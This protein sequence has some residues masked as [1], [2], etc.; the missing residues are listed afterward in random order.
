MFNFLF[1][2]ILL[3]DQIKKA[4]YDECGDYQVYQLQQ[5]RIYH[6]EFIIP[7]SRKNKSK[8]IQYE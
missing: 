5:Q 3:I 6:I 2:N 4:D 8:E 7:N 1:Y